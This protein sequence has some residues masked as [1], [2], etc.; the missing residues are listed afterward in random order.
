MEEGK[1]EVHAKN[2]ATLIYELDS[3]TSSVVTIKVN[4]DFPTFYL[5]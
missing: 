3:S 1:K 2:E 4:V 5:Q